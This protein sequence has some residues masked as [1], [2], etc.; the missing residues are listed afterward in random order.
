LIVTRKPLLRARRIA[1]TALSNTPSWQ[2]RLVVALAAA[3]EVDRERQVRDGVYSSMCFD[4]RI[5]LVHK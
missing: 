5:A 1:A 4:S 2:T 3:I